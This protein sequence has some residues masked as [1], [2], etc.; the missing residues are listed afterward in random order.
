MLDVVQ[1]SLGRSAQEVQKELLTRLQHFM[2]DEPQ[3]DDITLM[4]IRRDP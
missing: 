4:T 2:G 1:G 3:F